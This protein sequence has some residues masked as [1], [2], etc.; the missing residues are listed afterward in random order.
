M[1]T[2]CSFSC[3]RGELAMVNAGKKG[4]PMLVPMLARA[5]MP[6]DLV[7]VRHCASVFRNSVAS[8]DRILFLYR[9]D[10]NRIRNTIMNLPVRVA[11][12]SRV[13]GEGVLAIAN[14]CCGFNDP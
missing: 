2:L 7:D 9:S 10:T 6:G 5:F 1:P 14:F 3:N 4:M 11:H 12:A 8:P 13:S